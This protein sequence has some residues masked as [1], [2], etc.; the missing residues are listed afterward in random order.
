[1]SGR[2]SP[3]AWSA[4]ANVR[5]SKASR[6]ASACLMTVSISAL[7][8]ADWLGFDLRELPFL[9][10]VGCASELD[11]RLAHDGQHQF[12]TSEVID[13]RRHLAAL[14]IGPCRVEC[15]EGAI[16]LYTRLSSVRIAAS[17]I[18]ALRRT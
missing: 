1:M 16:V 11:Q 18:P 14:L 10:I 9:P 17:S 6:T 13:P 4:S 15:P 5:R 3:T 7:V 8:L 12:L 2:S